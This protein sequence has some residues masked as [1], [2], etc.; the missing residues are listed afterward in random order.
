MTFDFAHVRGIIFDLDDTLVKT[1]LDF[2]RLKTEIGCKKDD[3]IL[4][5]IDDLV[6]PLEKEKA[7]KIV[8]NHELDDARSSVWLPGAE[9]FVNM[10]ISHN[11]PLAIV[12]RNCKAAT[13]IKIKRNKIPISRIVTREDAPAK[14]D[15]TALLDIA[16]AWQINSL[17]IAYIGDYIYDIEAAHNANMQAW[18][19]QAKAK[20]SFAQNLRF[21]PNKK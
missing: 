7:N 11:L 9:T 13:M 8:L 18:L 10:A 20:I 12:T 21:I 2:A 16:D 15:P 6:C 14:P 4:S 5:F 19:Y 3:D 1:Q 17:D